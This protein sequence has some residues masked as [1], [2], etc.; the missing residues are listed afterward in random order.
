VIFE[1]GESSGRIWEYL[2]EHGTATVSEISRSLKM[3]NGML[4]MA[5]GWLAREDKVVF[6]GE[7]KVARLSLK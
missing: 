7:G 6:E 4:H 5:I 3:N 2:H 1:I